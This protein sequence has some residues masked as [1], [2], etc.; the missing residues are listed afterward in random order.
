MVAII[1]TNSSV[2]KY[3]LYFDNFFT[4]Y[5]LLSDLADLGVRSI[6]T[7]RE[8]RTG[9]ANKSL[10][11]KKALKKK[12]RGECDYYCDGKVFVAMWNDNA[13][14]AIASYWET[15]EPIRQAK[16]RVR[17]GGQKEFTQP[18]IIYSYNQG[19]GYKM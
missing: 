3:E 5:N 13:V 12:E 17:G 4:S 6:G 7:V 9:Q 1:I 16:R 8:N 11:S 14:V 2:E 19:M 18:H 15:H 10:I